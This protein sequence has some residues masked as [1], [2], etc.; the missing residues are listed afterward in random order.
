[1]ASRKNEGPLDIKKGDLKAGAAELESGLQHA[2]EI[3]GDDIINVKAMREAARQHGDV[4]LVKSDL[5]DQEQREAA[6]GTREQ[7]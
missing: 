5:D 6:P 2:P 1:M 3:E 7:P 4:F